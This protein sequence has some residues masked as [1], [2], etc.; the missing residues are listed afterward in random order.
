MYAQSG[1]LVQRWIPT[2]SDTLQLDS[3]SIQAGSFTVLDIP[4]SH[5]VFLPLEAKLIWRSKPPFDSVRVAYRRLPFS[6][7]KAYQH[8]DAR[9]IESNFVITPYYYNATEAEQKRKQFIDFGKVDYA[10]SFGRALSMGNNQDVVLNSQFN[11]QLDGDLGDSIRVTGA[12]TDNNIPF[13]PEGNTQQ[14]QEFD[15]LFIQLRRKRLTLTAGDYDIKRPPGYFLNF[16]KRVQGALIA[17]SFNTP[18]G[19]RN[20]IRAGI[21]LSST[22]NFDG[23]K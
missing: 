15:R 1:T 9:R 4:D 16:Y 19:G 22:K 10:G 6:L 11:L 23:A 20:D 14:L 7:F 21:G 8:K 3:L 13:Q 12:I 2:K 5:Y 18:G 17:T